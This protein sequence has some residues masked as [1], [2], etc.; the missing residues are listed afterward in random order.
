MSLLVV[1]AAIVAAMLLLWAAARNATTV[2]VLEISKGKV[3]V[4]RGGIAP[5]VLSDIRDVAARPKVSHATVRITRSRGRAVVDLHGELS[6][7]QRQRIRNVIGTV[8]LQK[9]ARKS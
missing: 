4:T 8:P 1:I 9:L 5:R 6:K 2:C 7:D 3:T